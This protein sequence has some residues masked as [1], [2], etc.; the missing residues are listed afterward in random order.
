MHNIHPLIHSSID[1]LPA[2]GNSDQGNCYQSSLARARTLVTIGTYSPILSK[3]PRTGSTIY[4]R[5]T[6]IS[7]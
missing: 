3:S 7:K 5:N 6:N 4:N 2:L 1:F